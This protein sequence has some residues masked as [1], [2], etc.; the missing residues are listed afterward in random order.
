MDQDQQDHY[1]YHSDY[2]VYDFDS[3]DL[4]PFLKIDRN[5]FIEIVHFVPIWR[6]LTISEDTTNLNV[7]LSSDWKKSTDWDKIYRW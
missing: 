2:T 7:I 1:I 3:F 6:F 5:S 4:D